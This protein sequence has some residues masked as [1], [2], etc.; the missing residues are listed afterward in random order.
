[1]KFPH[2][3]GLCRPKA[4]V[5]A[6]LLTVLPLLFSR[7]FAEQFSYPKKLLAEVLVIAAAGA[8]A[9]GVIWGKAAV[10]RRSS[11][12]W[13]LAFLGVAVL[14][15]CLN[16]PVPT[17]SLVEA[18][19]F[20]CGPLW[21][22]LLIVW[23]GGEARVRT[24]AML[25]AVGGTAVAAIALLQWAGHDP[26]LFGG[27]RIVWGTMVGRMRLYSTFGNPN[28]VAGYLIGAIF[29]ALALAG[30]SSTLAGKAAWCASGAAIFAA[31]VGTRSRGAWVG[32]AAGLLIARFVWR[33]EAASAQSSS[34][35][36]AA[37]GVPSAQCL[38]VP[39]ALAF[40]ASSLGQTVPVL[41]SRLEGRVYLWR[42]SWPMFAEHPLLGSGW[43][44]FQLRFLDLQARFL[45]AHPEF[46]R[47]WSNIRQLHNDPLQILLEAG[48][49]GLVAFGWVLWAF[50]R[51]ARRALLGA[52][53]STRLWIGASAGG[54]TAILVNSCFNFQLAIPPTLLL[55]FTLLAFPSLLLGGDSTRKEYGAPLGPEVEEMKL[56]SFG[57]R[58]VATLAVVGF[59]ALL[60]L[61]I[62]R[63]AAAE[64]DYMLA[65]GYE[66]QGEIARAEQVFRQGLK[67]APLHGRLRYGLARALYLQEMYPAALAEAELA[68]RTYADSHLEV[69]KAR[70]QDQMGLAGPALASYR[71]ALALD[72]TLKSV[73][74]DIERLSGAHL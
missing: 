62:A 35:V 16:S 57:V 50:G 9:V 71:H 27:Y 72:P 10:P 63:R 37:P 61:Q 19:Y 23:G 56:S 73:Q 38:V 14:L 66:R 22:V 47:Y 1:M 13:P 31:V 21:L 53:R 3:F 45:Q 7:S 2:V 4:I 24:L 54:T 46:V 39:A 20:L 17:L 70:I 26:L 48:A 69:L 12:I 34:V 33:G 29:L 65:L 44:T 32:L 30:V 36:A 60:L 51:E 8:W 64:Y 43:G 25:V 68:G 6:G 15:S 59:A 28:F 42:V 55:L 67:Q 11:L 41:L 18:E 40:L 58:V 5:A 74:A 49:L 52:S